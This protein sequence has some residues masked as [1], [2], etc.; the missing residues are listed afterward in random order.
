MSTATIAGPATTT[1][2]VRV[3]RRLVG[4]EL[5]KLRTTPGAY[6]ALAIVAV[7]TVVSVISGVE[8][9]GHKGTAPLG[10]VDNVNKTLAVSGLTSLVMLVMGILVAAGEFRHRTI[11]ATY[12]AEPRRG[13]VLV[14]QLTTIGGLGLIVGAVTFG[15]AYA[16]AVPMFAAKGVHHL[17]V[18]V[19]RLWVA[20]ALASAC[21]GL[22]GVAL[23]ALAR[24]T[25]AAIVGGVLW[26][27]GLEVGILQPA[28][29]ELDKWLPTGAGI[30]LTS[31]GTDAAHLLAPGP[32]ALVLVGWATLLSLV[33]VR[34]TLQREVR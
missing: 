4:I 31:T 10:T 32:A 12:L 26:V 8:L 6:V 25:V 1:E 30:A 14:A 23:G 2:R 21:F 29:P 7:L 3:L 28:I 15:V 33:A 20:C 16:I 11:V 13:R 22:L 19:P 27:Q 34:F 5:F 17:G 9:A 18:D 24:N